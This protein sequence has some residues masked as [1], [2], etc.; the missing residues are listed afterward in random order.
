M[1]AELKDTFGVRQDG[2]V[3][4]TGVLQ[5]GPAAKAGLKPGDVIVQVGD[6]K[7]NHVSELLAVV[8]G[9]KPG[10]PIKFHILRKDKALELEVTPSQRPKTKLSPRH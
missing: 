9:V 8:A 1:S 5:N 7:V 6:N 3:A 4:V 10:T 2:G